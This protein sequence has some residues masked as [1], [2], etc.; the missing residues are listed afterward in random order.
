V[1][2]GAVRTPSRPPT[3]CSGGRRSDGTGGI[4]GWG[5]LLRGMRSESGNW[6]ESLLWDSRYSGCLGCGRWRTETLGIW[7]FLAMV[8]HMSCAADA[9]VPV[10]CLVLMVVGCVRGSRFLLFM[11]P[12]LH[13]LAHRLT[14]CITLCVTCVWCCSADSAL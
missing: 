7:C 9:R 6:G 5:I 3:L 13:L 4:R 11:T 10:R 8:V 2:E 1:K 14:H 12:S